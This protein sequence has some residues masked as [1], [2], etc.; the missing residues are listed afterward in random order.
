MNIYL[1]IYFFPFPDA[2]FRPFL[3]YF[4]YQPAKHFPHFDYFYSLTRKCKLRFERIKNTKGQSKPMSNVVIRI[5]IVGWFNDNN[6]KLISKRKGIFP[7][8]IGSLLKKNL[9]DFLP[10]DHLKLTLMYVRIFI[11]KS[12]MSLSSIKLLLYVNKGFKIVYIKIFNGKCCYCPSMFNDHRYVILIY[13][14]NAFP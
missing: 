10:Q 7:H 12:A 11:V 1:V 3:R 5:G 6:L 13:I 4:Y 8:K 14:W 2:Q 9:S